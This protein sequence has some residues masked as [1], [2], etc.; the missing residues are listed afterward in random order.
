MWDNTTLADLKELDPSGSGRLQFSFA[1]LPANI[2]NNST[3]RRQSMT[4][5]LAV[6]AKR[7]DEHNVPQEIVSNV[8]RT[9][10]VQSALS[11]KTRLVRTIGPFE[12]T[13]PMPTQPDIPST[14]TVLV[15]VGNS[16]NAVKNVVYTTTL[17][18]YVQ[19]LGKTYPDGGAVSYN[20]DTRQITWTVGDV[21]P[22]VGFSSSAKEFA[23][24]V[25]FLPSIGQRT[26]TPVIINVERVAGKDD[27]TG[28]IV[29]ATTPPLDVKIESDPAFK[30]GDD[31]VGG[32]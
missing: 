4:I 18:S 17:P 22:G 21:S 16:F 23:Y 2:T 20:A 30:Y 25:S 13:G 14:Y 12:N 24:Q 26:T 31:K 7:L 32:K 1:S 27:F 3:F 9:V 15:S 6:H 8:T 19:W 10:Q 28:T 29:S 11:L 5:N